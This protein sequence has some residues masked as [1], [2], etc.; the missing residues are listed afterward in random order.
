MKGETK[1]LWI[2]FLRN[3]REDLGIEMDC[4]WIKISDKQK[5]L[6]QVCE[7]AFSASY[8]RFCVRHFNT[9]MPAGLS[10]V[11]MVRN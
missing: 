8:H 2:W 5:R 1:D 7:E 9:C 10:L 6:I 11:T 4:E 3:V